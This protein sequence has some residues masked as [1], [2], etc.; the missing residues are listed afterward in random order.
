MT[1]LLVL[2]SKP[3]PALVFTVVSAIITSGRKPANDLAVQAMRG[4]RTGTVYLYPRPRLAGGFAYRLKRRLK[5]WRVAPWYVRRTLRRI[6]FRFDRFVNPGLGRI[7]ALFRALSQDDPQVLACMA[8]KQPSSGML[9]LALGIADGGYSRFVLAG[10]SFEITH[11]YA[12]NPLVAERGAQSRHADTDIAVLKAL[13]RRF[14]TI[15]T[16]E[17][18]VHERAGLPMLPEAARTA[19]AS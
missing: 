3:D 1:T 4:L 10:F 7:H 19:A 17:P 8:R 5:D 2:G 11:A 16:S 9:A 18:V 14:G 6:G 13:S 12:D 15:F